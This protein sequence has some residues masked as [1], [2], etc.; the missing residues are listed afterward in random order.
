M[1][2]SPSVS[3]NL[4]DLS[5]RAQGLA[6][7]HRACAG[8]GFPV[9]IRLL[10]AVAPEP[11]VMVNATGCLEVV[12]TIYPHSAWPVPWLHNAFENSAATASGV[13]AA[14]RALTAR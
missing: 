9:L 6:P 8:C 11:V 12:S 4:R 1:S 14:A 2:T 5:K 7:G 3:L 13:E 10:L